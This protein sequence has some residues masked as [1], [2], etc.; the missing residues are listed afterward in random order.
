MNS[1]MWTGVVVL[2]F[3]LL[4]IFIIAS[5]VKKAAFRRM[6]RERY[7]KMTGKAVGKVLN[8]RMIKTNVR[9]T[10]EGE[11]YK[12]KCM[13]S[14]EFETEDGR[15]FRNEDEGSGAL[16]ERKAQKI[17]YNPEDPEDNCTQ[18]VWDDKMG[19]SDA[20]GGFF[21]LVIMAGIVLALYLVFKSKI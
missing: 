11:D 12:L 5:S 6:Q 13:I 18:Y 14:Y 2:C 8:R 3:V 17:R 7:R 21:F 9:N 4:L 1:L 19:I 10:R 20:I 16:W 15:V